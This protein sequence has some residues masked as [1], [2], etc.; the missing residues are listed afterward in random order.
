MGF[1]IKKIMISDDKKI[2]FK[3]IALGLQICLPPLPKK[4]KKYIYIYIYIYLDSFLALSS[5]FFGFFFSKLV[6]KRIKKCSSLNKYTK[7]K[8]QCVD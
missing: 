2:S 4:K 1:V 3:Y 8:K 7:G 5:G 6:L